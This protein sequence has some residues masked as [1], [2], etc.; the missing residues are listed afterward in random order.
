MT[1]R[2]QFSPYTQV[3][4]GKTVVVE[5]IARTFMVQQTLTYNSESAEDKQLRNVIS[6][7]LM[8]VAEMTEEAVS[9]VFS[10]IPEAN[11]PVIALGKLCSQNKDQFVVIGF[12]K[13]SSRECAMVPSANLN[14]QGLLLD[15]TSGRQVQQTYELR[16]VKAISNTSDETLS[17]EQRQELERERLKTSPFMD[18][19]ILKIFLD[20]L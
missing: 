20:L 15:S 7:A 5:E 3:E 16:N 17:R 6:S 14:V 1:K 12:T 10:I 19:E 11:I 9:S 2:A 13:N 18:Y 8:K 4:V